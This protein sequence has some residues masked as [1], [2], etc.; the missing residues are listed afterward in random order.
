[1]ATTEPQP[2]QT[3]PA[4]KRSAWAWVSGLLLL[5]CIGLLVWALTLQS[6]RDSA[7]EQAD[8]LQAQV[9][10][11]EQQADTAGTALKAGY[12]AL[13]QQLGATQADVDAAQQ[14]ITEA[15]QT[16]QQAQTDAKA[17]AD[18]VADSASGAAE[19][20]QARV[21]QA[22]A[23][24]QEAGAKASLAADCAK[25]YLSTLGSVFSGTKVSEVRTQLQGV[26]ANC[27]T[28]LAGS[29]SP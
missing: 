6:D 27:K 28:A 13:M 2:A 15:E 1:M 23:Q 12:D 19:Q 25:T 22:Q 7:R 14:R 11:N 4:S 16:I 24:A 20:A 3:P 26:A 8:A 9:T 17:A 18:R 29:S 21:E 5:V 10:A